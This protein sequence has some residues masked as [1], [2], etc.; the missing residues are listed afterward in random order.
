MI[1]ISSNNPLAERKLIS[2]INQ[3]GIQVCI[4][5]GQPY[6]SHLHFSI[7]HHSLTIL[8]ASK[9]MIEF[10]LPIDINFM[11]NQL[12]SIL[13]D[14][15]VKNVEFIYFPFRQLLIFNHKE[16]SLRNTHNIILRYLLLAGEKGIN[17]K[18]LYCNIWPKDKEIQFNKLDTHL[19]N[20]KNFLI[21]NLGLEIKI[22][23]QKNFVYLNLSN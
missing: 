20:L 5:E 9:E 13:N 16:T 2:L 21:E 8:L 7:D 15:E 18:D 4:N 17:R 14:I 6:F 10:K 19:T 12:M 3:K 23:S 22:V 11:F 1:K